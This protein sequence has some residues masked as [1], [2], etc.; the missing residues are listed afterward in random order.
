MTPPWTCD[1]AVSGS[2]TRPMSW[3][4]TTRSTV[5]SPVRGSTSTSAKWAPNVFIETSSGFGIRAP[6]PMTV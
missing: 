5:T 1:R 3:T 2:M 4:A 6:R